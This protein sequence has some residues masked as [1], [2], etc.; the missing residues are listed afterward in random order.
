MGS[1]KEIHAKECKLVMLQDEQEAGEVAAAEM[2]KE[3]TEMSGD[4][5]PKICQDTTAL[6]CAATAGNLECVELLLNN[7]VLELLLA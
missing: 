4:W 2:K 5:I 6:I 1:K 7:K 3:L